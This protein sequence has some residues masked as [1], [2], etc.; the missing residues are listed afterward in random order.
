[1]LFYENAGEYFEEEQKRLIQ[2]QSA[3]LPD[4]GRITKLLLPSAELNE[5]DH[6]P[7][8]SLSHEVDSFEVDYRGIVGERHQAVTRVSGA[9]L[10]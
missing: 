9:S 1:M 4:E 8:Y 3:N 2:R 6:F 7:Y 5:N 10:C